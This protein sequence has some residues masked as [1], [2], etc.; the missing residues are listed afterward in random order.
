M[1]SALVSRET[2][3]NT[4]RVNANPQ[5]RTHRSIKTAG[6][7]LTRQKDNA[8]SKTPPEKSLSEQN[9]AHRRTKT[10]CKT[11]AEWY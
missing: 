9:G 6:K 5:L 11:F 10:L 7:R 2:F 3:A 1:K 8:P 4:P